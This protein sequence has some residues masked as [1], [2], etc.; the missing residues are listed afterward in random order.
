MKAF[1]CDL[2]G[3]YCSEVKRIGEKNEFGEKNEYGSIIN[4]KEICFECYDS[5]QAWMESRKGGGSDE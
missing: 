5:L 2:C 3:K 1:K 4:E